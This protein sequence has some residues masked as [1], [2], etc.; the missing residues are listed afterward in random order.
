MPP[1]SQETEQDVVKIL[2]NTFK[3]NKHKIKTGNQ[4]NSNNPK[5]QTGIE[6][7]N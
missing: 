3:R 4:N 2:S 5:H 6:E 7:R 1:T